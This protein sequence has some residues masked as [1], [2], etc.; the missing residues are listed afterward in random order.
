M[1]RSAVQTAL[2]AASGVLLASCYSLSELRVHATVRSGPDSVVLGIWIRAPGP[3]LSDPPI[4]P[5]DAAVAILFY[6]WDVAV[7]TWVAVSAPFDPDLDVS[8]GPIGALSGIVLPGVTL[9]PYV[10]PA[11]HMMFP[12]PDVQ[13]DAASFRSLVARIEAGDGLRAYRDIVGSFPWDGGSEAMLAIELI[14]SHPQA[15]QQGATAGERLQPGDR[16]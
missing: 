13:L 9:M 8:F 12:P 10:Y 3:V 11:Y 4:W 14:G 6:P 7:S 1:I 15:A 2:L 16:R 5:F